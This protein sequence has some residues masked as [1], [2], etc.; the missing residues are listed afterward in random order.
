M[1]TTDIWPLVLCAELSMQFLYLRSF[2]H[3]SSSVIMA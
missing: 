3:N 1:K 2:Q